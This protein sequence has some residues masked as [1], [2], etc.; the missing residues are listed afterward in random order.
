MFTTPRGDFCCLARNKIFFMSSPCLTRHPSHLGVWYSNQKP[1]VD[2]F[3]L[4]LQ[5][6]FCDIWYYVCLVFCVFTARISRG[7]PQEEALYIIIGHMQPGNSAPGLANRGGADGVKYRNTRHVVWWDTE[8]ECLVGTSYRR[9]LS[10]QK[11][12]VSKKNIIT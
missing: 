2:I 5:F 10:I 4:L 1:T 12:A 3:C 11:I 9:L 7:L 6:Y 8:C